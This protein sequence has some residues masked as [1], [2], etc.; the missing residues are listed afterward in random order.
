MHFELA[1]STIGRIKLSSAET[2]IPAET[3][4]TIAMTISPFRAMEMLI[5]THTIEVPSMGTNDEIA[6]STA[7]STL[8]LKPKM[9]SR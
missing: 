6:V 8:F 1:P 4:N 5:G 2:T 7:R 9:S 3:K